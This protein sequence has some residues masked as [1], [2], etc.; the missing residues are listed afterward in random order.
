MHPG[1]GMKL[2]GHSPRP[3]WTQPITHVGWLRLT[4][5]QT[6]VRLLPICNSARR[7]SQLGSALPPFIPASRIEDQSLPWG[8][9]FT[10][11]FEGQEFHLHEAQVIKDLSVFV[12]YP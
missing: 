7:D 10:S 4:T 2:S 12:L 9:C 5:I 6:C 11:A 8:M 1:S 3:F